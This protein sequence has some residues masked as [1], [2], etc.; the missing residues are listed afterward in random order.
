VVE[1]AMKVKSV[2][3]HHQDPGTY[4][5]MMGFDD[6][7]LSKLAQGAGF[8]RV[9]VECHMDVEPGSMIRNVRLDTLLDS[10]PNPLAP[11]V[12]EAFA[13]SLTQSE[14]DRFLEELGRSMTEGRR[15]QRSVV[16]YVVA[17]K[18]L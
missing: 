16:A 14:Q 8:E 15:V 10:A 1:L 4:T 6:R 9:H 11:T 18:A 2:F 3:G 7:D 5:A 17:Q 12:R 13:A